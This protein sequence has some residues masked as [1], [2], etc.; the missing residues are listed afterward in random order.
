MNLEHNKKPTIP[1]PQYGN[2]QLLEA[3]IKA[4]QQDTKLCIASD[5]TKETEYIRTKKIA[6]WKKGLP[7]IHKRPMVFLLYK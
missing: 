3:L 1:Y 2:I 6:A 4:C 7:D 5:L